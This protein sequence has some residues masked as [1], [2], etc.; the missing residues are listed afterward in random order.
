MVEGIVISVTFLDFRWAIDSASRRSEVVD[1][2][3]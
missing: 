3:P 2:R 1:P